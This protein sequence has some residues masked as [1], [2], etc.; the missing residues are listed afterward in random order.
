MIRLLALALAASLTL[1]AGPASAQ[2]PPDRNW[3]ATTRLDV[4]AAY[5]L[6]NDNHTGR[7]QRSKMRTSGGDWKTA[8]RWRWS[9]RRACRTL[10]DIAPC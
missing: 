1:L 4:E 10:E 6:L 2:T 3:A 8:G 9:G 7:C 5:A